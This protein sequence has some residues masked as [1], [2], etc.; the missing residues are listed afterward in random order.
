MTASGN[1]PTPKL[2]IPTHQSVTYELP[3]PYHKTSIQAKKMKKKNAQQFTTLRNLQQAAANNWNR[4]VIDSSTNRL[5]QIEASSNGKL[6]PINKTM[7]AIDER[8][9]KNRLG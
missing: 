3:N 1:S 8:I 9:M 7:E 5:D 2:I 4:V 6:G